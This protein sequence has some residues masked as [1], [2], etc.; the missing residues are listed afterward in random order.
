M[1]DLPLHP[2]ARPDNRSGAYLMHAG[3]R[4]RYEIDG[5]L[6]RVNEFLHDGDALVA[7]DG[8]SYETV[9]SYWLE[10]HHE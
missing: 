9:R 5:R 2:L 1:S 6:G 7:F 10:P 3:D 4:V 8:G